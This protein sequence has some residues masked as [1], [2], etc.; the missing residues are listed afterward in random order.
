MKNFLLASVALSLVWSFGYPIHGGDEK[1]PKAILT[2]AMKALGGEENL[3]K[4]KAVS[5]KVK[6][7]ITFGGESSDFTAESISKGL[8]HYRSKFSGEFG[9]NKVEAVTVVDG[10]KGWRAFMG[11]VM[12][13]DADALANEKRM[14]YLRNIPGTIVPLLGNGFKVEP[15]AAE[16]VNGKPA[17]G[18]KVTPKDG[19]VFTLYF[20]E[21]SGLPVKEVA[22]VLDF[23]GTEF[24]QETLFS[25]YKDFGAIKTATKTVSKR[26]GEP[27]LEAELTE[28]K[29]LD[30]VGAKTFAKPE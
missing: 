25:D 28:F 24:T 29:V 18:I 27:L 12:D 1:D 15:A 23:M 10:D 6:G 20:D 14:I 9:G 8:D 16:K 22:K 19:K 17:A 5:A 13:L 11:N 2:K 21:E 3:A 30:S 4:I 26:D 7:K